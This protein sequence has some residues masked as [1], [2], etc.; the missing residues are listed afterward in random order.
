M[1]PS[2]RL[3]GNGSAYTHSVCVCGLKIQSRPQGTHKKSDNNKKKQQQK[4]ALLFFVCFFASAR[5]QLDEIG[6]V[7]SLS[8]LVAHTERDNDIVCCCLFFVCCC[9]IP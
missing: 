4:Q 7:K 3:N 9:D 5:R 6:G 2:Q 1:L 8:H